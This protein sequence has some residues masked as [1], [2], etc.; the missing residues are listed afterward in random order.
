MSFEDIQGGAIARVAY[1]E[2]LADPHTG[3]QR[4]SE[5]GQANGYA[6]LGATSLV[7]QNPANAT[8]TPTASKIPIADGNGKLAS[9]WGGSASTLA[10]LDAGGKVPTAELGGVGAD[11]TKY[12]RGDQTWQVISAFTGGTLTSELLQIAGTAAAPGIAISGDTNTGMFSPS[13]DK[14]ALAVNG[15]QRFLIQDGVPA[16]Q[17]VCTITGAGGADRVL[18]V[19]GTT[20]YAGITLAAPASN[21]TFLEFVA[22]NVKQAGIEYD[23]GVGARITTSSGCVISNVPAT[24]TLWAVDVN[25]LVTQK[26]GGDIALGTTTGTKIGTATNQKLGFYNATPITQGTAVADASGGATIDAEART[27]INALLARIRSLGLIAT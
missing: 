4:E 18:R 2:G 16:N 19:E 14:I 12:L 24:V 8:A 23:T 25:G 26:D 21:G 11:N 17:G 10:T 7:V 9:G 20:A 15:T 13:A 5:K 22:N 6:S 3:Y 27:A 1:H